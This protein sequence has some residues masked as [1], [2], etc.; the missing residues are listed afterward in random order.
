MTRKPSGRAEKRNVA[1][2]TSPKHDSA[3]IAS[4]VKA[5]AVT[6]ALW[7]WF[8][9]DWADWINHLGEPRDK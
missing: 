1:T 6:L 9:I 2:K 7:G 5:V 4:R 8:P 3:S